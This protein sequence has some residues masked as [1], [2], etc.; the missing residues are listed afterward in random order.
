MFRTAFPTAPE[1]VERKEAHW[2]KQNYDTAGANK[3]GKARFAGTWVTPE[4]ALTISKDYNLELVIAPLAEASPDPNM[5][6]RKSSK[7]LQQPT[8]TAS[9]AGAAPPAKRRRETS[10]A[11]PTT[12]AP[13]AEASVSPSK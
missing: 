4:V 7:G 8:P 5:V 10:P 12:A 2:V 1:D 11:H 6:Y 3:S 9:P 13:P